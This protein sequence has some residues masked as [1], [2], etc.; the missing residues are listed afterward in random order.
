[1]RGSPRERGDRDREIPEPPPGL[2]VGLAIARLLIVAAPSHLRSPPQHQVG[3][4][5]APVP[6]ALEPTLPG[7]LAVA[8]TAEG[9]SPPDAALLEDPDRE[10]FMIA[11]LKEAYCSGLL[12]WAQ[13]AAQSRNSSHRRHP[14]P[15]H[16]PHAVSLG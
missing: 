12:G 3:S 8:L 10:Q 4:R 14:R 1:M 7:G 2:A 9:M 11:T 13:D 5:A 6:A 16:Q 15:G